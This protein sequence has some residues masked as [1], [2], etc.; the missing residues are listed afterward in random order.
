[1]VI[2]RR[3]T[4][5]RCICHPTGDNDVSTLGESINDAPATEVR[6]RR[7][8]ARYITQP[9]CWIECDEISTFSEIDRSIEK[10]VAVNVGNSWVETETVGDFLKGVRTSTRIEST[11]VRDDFDAT[12]K[13]GSHHL[14]HL[15]D[16]G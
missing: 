12:I 16:K 7:H 14:L 8:I 9:I 10:I 1:M 3:A 11:S 6:I 5:D 15:S 13:T 2:C 4:D